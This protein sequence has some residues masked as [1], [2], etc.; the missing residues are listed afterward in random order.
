MFGNF[1]VSLDGLRDAIAGVVQIPVVPAV[2][3]AVVSW[4]FVTY[5]ARKLAHFIV[6]GNWRG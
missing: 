6:A 5:A 3:L 1:G 4:F 2:I